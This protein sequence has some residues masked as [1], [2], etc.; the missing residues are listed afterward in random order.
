MNM[1][2]M[3]VEAGPIHVA[4]VKAVHQRGRWPLVPWSGAAAGRHRQ[5]KKRKDGEMLASYARIG[6]R[7]CRLSGCVK[8]HRLIPAECIT[9]HSDRV[10]AV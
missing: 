6:N 10:S 5:K 9:L 2:E 3:R 1:Q 8:F 4:T 7:V